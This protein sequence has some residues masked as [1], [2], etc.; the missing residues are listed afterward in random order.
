[1]GTM[2][3]PAAPGLETGLFE[4][5]LVAG[6]RPVELDAHLGRLANSLELL[7]GAA[8]PAELR[9]LA[10]AHSRG[11]ELGR[12]RLTVARDGARLR[13]RA[14]ARAIEPGLVFPAWDRAVDLCPVTVAGGLGPYKWADRRVLRRASAALAEQQLPL[15]VDAAGDVLEAARANV[16]A[17]AGDVLLTPPTDGRILPG[18]ARAR[19]IEAAVQAGIEVREVG[20]TITDLAACG[21][22]FLTGSVRGVEPARSAGGTPLRPPGEPARTVARALRERW[23]GDVG[24]L[25]PAQ[26]RRH[27]VGAGGERTEAVVAGDGQGSRDGG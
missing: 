24:R 17:I 20:L 26:A 16:F 3:E 4:T 7:D 6:G 10:L 12:V 19:A 15:V 5:L 25:E 23:L 11:L 2:D 18:I 1:M 22:V 8:A 13:A 27:T 14:E 21:E 9:A